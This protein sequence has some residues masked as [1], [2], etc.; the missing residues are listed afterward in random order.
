MMEKGVGASD[1]V[2]RKH[3]VSELPV[4]IGFMEVESSGGQKHESN[5]I[6]AQ[7]DRKQWDASIGFMGCAI[8]SEAV[9]EEAG[10]GGGVVSIDLEEAVSRSGDGVKAA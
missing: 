2:N 9:W 1:G 8:G 7:S 3:G 6:M 10:S 4:P 5:L